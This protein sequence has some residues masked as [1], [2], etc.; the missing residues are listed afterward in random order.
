MVPE[1]LYD[2]NIRAIWQ[3]W[4]QI[5]MILVK[6][7]LNKLRSMLWV[8][9]L[10]KIAVM[11]IQAKVLVGTQ[12]VVLQYLAVQ[13]LVEVAFNPYNPSN[14]ILRCNHRPYHNLPTAMLNLLLRKPWVQALSWLPPTPFHPIRA[15]RVEYGLIQEVHSLPVIDS[16]F[17][18]FLSPTLSHM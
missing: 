12:E 3:P 14:P 6:P 9:V 11:I 5:N 2:V 7:G 13:L 16:P 15:K 10:L 17:Q 8:I 18:P 1:I 4:Q